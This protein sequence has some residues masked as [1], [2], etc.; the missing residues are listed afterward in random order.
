MEEE[1]KIDRPLKEW[2]EEDRKN[3]ADMEAKMKDNIFYDSIKK[4]DE[5]TKAEVSAAEEAMKVSQD[6]NVDFSVLKDVV[7]DSVDKNL[8]D[9]NKRR[10][11]VATA[12]NPIKNASRST[13][14]L[15]NLEEVSIINERNPKEEHG[16]DFLTDPLTEEG[17][18]IAK[19]LNE[20]GDE[21][22]VVDTEE[23]SENLVDGSFKDSEEQFLL[24]A[25]IGLTNKEDSEHSDSKKC[26]GYRFH[27]IDFIMGAAVSALILTILLSI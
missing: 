13:R 23:G 9:F 14:S 21:L 3:L 12:I 4:M 11:E 20:N 22:D 17:V 2:S 25:K 1:E 19:Q 5:A 16:S 24:D 18:D 27:W 26:K 10:P 15:R 7:S 6:E 8:A